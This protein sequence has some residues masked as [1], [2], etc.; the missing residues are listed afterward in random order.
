MARASRLSNAR[1]VVVAALVASLLIAGAML[2]TAWVVSSSACASFVEPRIEAA[3]SPLSQPRQAEEPYGPEER[4][5]YASWIEKDFALWKDT[6]I[7][8][9]VRA[10]ELAHHLA[11]CQP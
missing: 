7:T 5:F 3:G 11:G 2:P 6:G 9:Q 8:E 4:S 10:H 1:V